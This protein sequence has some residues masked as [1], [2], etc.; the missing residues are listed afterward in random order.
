MVRP[1]RT[2]WNTEP[3]TPG[4]L[5]FDNLRKI[6]AYTLTH[7]V[8]EVAA[9]AITLLAGLPPGLNSF[10]ILSIDLGTEVLLPLHASFYVRD[11]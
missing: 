4:R 7:L 1:L 10:M 2:R 9:I 3:S 8:A 6:I 5:I 11:H